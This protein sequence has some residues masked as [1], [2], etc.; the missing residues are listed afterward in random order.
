MKNWRRG[1]LVA[2]GGAVLMPGVQP[3]VQVFMC[4]GHKGQY[5]L[6]KWIQVHAIM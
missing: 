5:L 4:I 6:V 3:K 2:W 1:S